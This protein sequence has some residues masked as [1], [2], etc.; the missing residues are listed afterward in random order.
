MLKIDRSLIIN[1]AE[2]T[3]NIAIIKA[4]IAMAQSINIKV[5][6][7]G[8]EDIE[9]FIILKELKSYAIQGYLISKPIPAKEIKS[10]VERKINLP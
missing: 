8:V 9:Q 3:Q 4:I 2:G 10:L 7:E 1:I 5:V 6:V